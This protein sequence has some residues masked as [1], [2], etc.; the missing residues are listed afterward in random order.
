MSERYFVDPRIVDDRARLVGVEAHHLVHVM[1]GRPGDRVTLFDGSGLEF[2]A[3]VSELRRDEVEL[4][5]VARHEADRELAFRLTLAVALPKGDRQ[6]WLV[7]KA[8]ELGVA[9]VIP[10]RTARSV[11]KP[12]RGAIQR[13]ARWVVDA[14]KQCGRNRLMEIGE[15]RTWSDLLADSNEIPLR[16][17]AHPTPK[18]PACGNDADFEF[19]RVPAGHPRDE[20]IAAIGPEGGFTSEEVAAAREADW[21]AVNLGPRTLRIE[22]AATVLASLVMTHRGC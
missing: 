15:P 10:L 18:D 22:T 8:V 14:S 12:G 1:R 19:L 11:A 4:K 21:R 2:T 16:I 7:E 9:R 5:V 17:L 3:E 13:M 20:V 6:R